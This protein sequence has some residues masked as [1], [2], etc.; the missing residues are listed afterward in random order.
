MA[1]VKRGILF[2]LGLTLFSLLVLAVSTLIFNVFESAKEIGNEELVLDYIYELDTSIQRSFNKI[3]ESKSGINFETNGKYIMINETLPNLNANNL[4]NETTKFKQFLESKFPNVFLDDTITE[5]FPITIKPSGV[6]Y[7]HDKY[8]DD[9]II[10]EHNSN[11]SAYILYFFN[12]DINSTI[13]WTDYTP[14]SVDFTVIYESGSKNTKSHKINPAESSKIRIQLGSG[15]L[16]ININNN[17]ISID[18]NSNTN[19]VI[20]TTIEFLD[21]IRKKLVLADILKLTFNDYNI[22]KNGYIELV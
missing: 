17:E 7:K 22:I 11:A 4:K 14:G 18:N 16:D 6:I 21:N 10:I 5:N 15:N 19:V 1:K 2:T 3:V 9:R 12:K 8:G 13:E 20:K